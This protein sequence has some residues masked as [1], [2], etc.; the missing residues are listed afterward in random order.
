MFHA[1]HSDV[2]FEFASQPPPGHDF[3]CFLHCSRRLP[4]V[5]GEYTLSNP[6]LSAPVAPHQAPIE[7]KFPFEQA[8]SAL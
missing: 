1:G 4:E 5:M 3:T 7:A 2:A 8:Y 6:Y